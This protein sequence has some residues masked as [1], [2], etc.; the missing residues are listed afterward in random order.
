MSTDT[1][2][3]YNV[4]LMEKILRSVI[5]H[6]DEHYQGSWFSVVDYDELPGKVLTLEALEAEAKNDCGTSA[7][8]AGWA[9]LHDGWKVKE[10]A[11]PYS[12]SDIIAKGSRTIENPDYVGMGAEILGLGADEARN[13]FLVA[14]ETVAVAT[15]YSIVKTGEIPKELH[16]DWYPDDAPEDEYHASVQAEEVRQDLAETLYYEAQQKYTEKKE[17]K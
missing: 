6:P 5:N 13:L 15:L 17:K 3:K 8:I 11:T 16:P 2:T 12:S 1:K 7:C 4:A 9:L 10:M 14:D